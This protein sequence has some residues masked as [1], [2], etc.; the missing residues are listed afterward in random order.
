MLVNW[1]SFTLTML[2]AVFASK[3]FRFWWRQALTHMLFHLIWSGIML[4]MISVSILPPTSPCRDHEYLAFQ[5][6]VA[7]GLISI[8]ESRPC[9]NHWPIA[10]LLNYYLQAP[11]WKETILSPPYSLLIRPSSIEVLHVCLLTGV[12]S[13]PAK[14]FWKWGGQSCENVFAPQGSSSVP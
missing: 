8:G 11:L 3:K 14:R 4:S 13:G 12:I 6:L 1:I 10:V 9:T 2:L 7:S 5:P